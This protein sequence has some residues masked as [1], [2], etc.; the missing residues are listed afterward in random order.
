MRAPRT[1]RRNEVWASLPIWKFFWS[2]LCHN[3]N[4]SVLELLSNC[5]PIS[6]ASSGLAS[7]FSQTWKCS[8]REMTH[9]E[10]FG[11]RVCVYLHETVKK[12][13]SHANPRPVGVQL[14]KIDLL[15]ELSKSRT[16][17]GSLHLSWQKQLLPCKIH[18]FLAPTFLGSVSY[19]VSRLPPS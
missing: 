10:I 9:S 8:Y 7:G 4:L 6:M 17:T 13:K 3:F 11:V 16:H 14:F 15:F 18:H 5:A 19:H 12:K 1:Y 2:L